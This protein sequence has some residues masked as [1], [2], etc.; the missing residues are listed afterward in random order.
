MKSVLV[1]FGLVLAAGIAIGQEQK[2]AAAEE[3][4]AATAPAPAEKKEM[5]V[6]SGKPGAKRTRE[7]SDARHCL[8]LPTQHE[9]IVC[10]EKYL[11][12]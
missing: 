3:K 8:D 5:K 6:E 12:G 1:G 10:S 11:K 7:D 9:I 2:P 4:P